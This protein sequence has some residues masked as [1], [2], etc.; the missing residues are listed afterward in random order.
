MDYFTQNFWWLIPVGI[1]VMD[2]VMPIIELW[3]RFIFK[4]GYE[5]IS[6]PLYKLTTK[7][8]KK[9]NYYY[10]Y[11]H[12]TIGISY[13]KDLRSSFSRSSSAGL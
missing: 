7:E 13:H 9:E 1:I 5:D 11:R 10:R 6:T 3:V 4:K 2:L 12:S 8:L